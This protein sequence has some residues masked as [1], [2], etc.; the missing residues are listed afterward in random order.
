MFQ[1][2]HRVKLSATD[3]DAVA[4][5]PIASIAVQLDDNSSGDII[6][7]GVQTGVLV[8]MLV[9]GTLLLAL[10]LCAI[11]RWLDASASVA[12]VAVRRSLPQ[13]PPLQSNFGAAPPPSAPRQFGTVASLAAA[14]A[15]QPTRGER[16]VSPQRSPLPPPL[17]TQ[18]SHQTERAVPA[19][20]NMRW[21]RPGGL[22]ASLAA[23]SGPPQQQQHQ[24]NYNQ[25]QQSMLRPL[26]KLNGGG[27]GGGAAF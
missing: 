7:P 2:A 4:S 27:G 9:I 11:Y 19:T 21:Q 17:L 3:A 25:Q 8:G 5:E 10:A 14:A 6:S 23:T 12:R 20:N 15:H 13:P 22:L 24:Q 16:S 18:Q 26:N 1:T